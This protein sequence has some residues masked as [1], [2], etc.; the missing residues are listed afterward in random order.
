MEQS[1]DNWK[2]VYIYTFLRSTSTFEINFRLG[3]IFEINPRGKNMKVRIGRKREFTLSCFVKYFKTYHCEGV[4]RFE[5]NKLSVKPLSES[6]SL[7]TSITMQFTDSGITEV[8]KYIIFCAPYKVC[9]KK[10]FQ[11]HVARNVTAT[12]LYRR[13]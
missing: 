3:E 7:Y 13:M 12:R 11:T 8:T 9:R 4:A 1:G 2:L 5:N 10:S 6:D